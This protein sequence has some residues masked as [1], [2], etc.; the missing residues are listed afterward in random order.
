MLYDTSGI[1]S[2]I[3]LY[4]DDVRTISSEYDCKV[5]T[6]NKVTWIFTILGTQMEYV[7]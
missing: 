4:A 6:Y 7:L 1:F 2:L 3:K 5:R